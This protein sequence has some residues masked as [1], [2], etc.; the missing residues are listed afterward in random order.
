MLAH[1]SNVMLYDGIIA[2][3]TAAISPHNPGAH[4]I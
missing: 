4:N 3:A 2:V 1:T